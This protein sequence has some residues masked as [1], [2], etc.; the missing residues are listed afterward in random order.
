VVR[1]IT[2]LTGMCIIRVILAGRRDPR[3]LAALRD[4]KCKNSLET[5]A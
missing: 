3:C 5:I 1:E 4:P 2:G